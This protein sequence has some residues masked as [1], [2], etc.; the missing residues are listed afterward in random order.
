MPTDIVLD[1]RDGNWLQ[2]DAAAIHARASDFMLDQPLRRRAGVTKPFRR[3]L[4]HD[5]NDGLTINFANDYPGGVT[6]NGVAK[7]TPTPP[8]PRRAGGLDAIV[9]RR[10]PELLVDGGIRFTWHGSDQ[11]LVGTPPEEDKIVSLQTLLQRMQDR[12][13]ELEARVQTL[14][15]S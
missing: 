9:P 8:P 11:L 2:L 6:I 12:I 3:A 1:Q 13:D 10:R 14:E 5:E 4:V 15:A 7:I